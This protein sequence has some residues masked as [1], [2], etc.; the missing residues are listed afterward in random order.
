MKWLQP[1][2]VKRRRGVS[3]RRDCVTFHDYPASCRSAAS[4]MESYLVTQ[5]KQ[6]PYYN[7]IRGEKDS[8]YA[9]QLPESRVSYHC[10]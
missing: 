6:T 8:K 2:A 10:N 4:E 9:A 5:W 7:E 3:P 1:V